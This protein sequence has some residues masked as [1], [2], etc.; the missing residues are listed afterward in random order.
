[1]NVMNI[2]LV[3]SSAGLAAFK[4]SNYAAFE[5]SVDM[6]DGSQL[7]A[8]STSITIGQIRPSV[9]KARKYGEHKQRQEGASDSLAAQQPP[10]V[11]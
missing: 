3:I 8:N 2:T 11:H 7:K 6:Q 4:P 10:S 1:M 5:A 9:L